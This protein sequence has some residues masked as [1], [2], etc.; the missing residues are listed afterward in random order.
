MSS[1][2]LQ[3]WIVRLT[4]FSL[5]A[6]VAASS[7]FWIL[8]NLNTLANDTRLGSTKTAATARAAPEPNLIPQVAT[9]LGAKNLIAATP[10]SE[11]IALQARLQLQGV[12]AVG[13][14][15]GAALISVDGKPA[16]PYRV[17]S[18]I[19]DGLEV[20]AVA[21]RGASIG[22]N[23]ITVFTLELPLKN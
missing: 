23:G 18:A 5:W 10:A 4:T 13:T 7:T 17:G 9:A 15:Q 14:G 12:L 2:L 21:A 19:E 1:P 8:Q 6:L 3:F 20:T 22:T 11:L 16:K